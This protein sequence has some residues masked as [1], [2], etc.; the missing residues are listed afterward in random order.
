MNKLDKKIIKRLREIFVL[1]DID[2]E[3]I[4]EGLKDSFV[5]A[6]ARVS[7]AMEQLRD[8]IIM[9]IPGIKNAIDSTK[10]KHD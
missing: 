2:D 1:E 9:E 4:Y 5:Y 6:L 10:H 7:I 8:N 3:Q